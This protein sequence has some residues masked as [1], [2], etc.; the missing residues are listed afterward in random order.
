MEN[1]TTP[2]LTKKQSLFCLAYFKSGC[3]SATEAAI[4]AG[5]SKHTAAV[6]ATENLKKPNIIQKMKELQ[7]A[8]DSRAVASVQERKEVLTQIIRGRLNDFCECGE[9]GVW[10]NIGPETLRSAALKAVTSK[11]IVGKE[12]ADDA[13]FIHAEL[14]SPIDAIKELN[15][16]EKVYEEGT[17]INNNIMLIKVVYDPP[18]LPNL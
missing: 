2:K 9:D 15:K 18:C 16:M 13:L 12:G 1:N 14:H 5:Y 8:V 17:T 7:A 6:I 10:F 4:A 11:T 3:S